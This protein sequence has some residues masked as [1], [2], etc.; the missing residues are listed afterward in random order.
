MLRHRI[1]PLC[2]SLHCLSSPVSSRLVK[3]LLLDR[4]WH[5]QS[6]GSRGHSLQQLL[7][8]IERLVRAIEDQLVAQPLVPFLV[9][10]RSYP[11]SLAPL[12]LISNFHLFAFFLRLP[13]YYGLPFHHLDHLA[14]RCHLWTVCRSFFLSS[15]G[16]FLALSVFSLVTRCHGPAAIQQ[17]L[18]VA[19]ETVGSE[20]GWMKQLSLVLSRAIKADKPKSRNDTPCLQTERGKW[21][22]CRL[23]LCD[24]S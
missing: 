12:L 9:L 10:Q 17:L 24:R 5:V 14:L 15:H 8:Y 2:E 1:G 6:R 16:L 20:R 18:F 13:L 4:L 7:F 19:S 23:C 22:Q 3:K 21:Q 11:F